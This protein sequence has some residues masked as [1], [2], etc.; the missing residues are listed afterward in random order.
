M[1]KKINFEPDPIEEADRAARLAYERNHLKKRKINGYDALEE[2][3]DNSAIWA[4]QARWF[5]H[6]DKERQRN[7]T[8]GDYDFYDDEYV[9]E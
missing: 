8:N 5:N 7:I 1:I 2:L 6:E 4:D 3:K 9:D